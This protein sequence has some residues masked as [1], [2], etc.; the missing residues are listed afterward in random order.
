MN[1]VLKRQWFLSNTGTFSQYRYM[2]NSI[3]SGE[4]EVCAFEKSTTGHPDGANREDHWSPG[5]HPCHCEHVLAKHE[6]QKQAILTQNRCPALFTGKFAY[7]TMYKLA[8][9]S[10]ICGLG[11]E[12]G[13]GDT[14][15]GSTYLEDPLNS[16]L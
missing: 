6:K 11:G 14:Q 4:V 15:F 13:L 3:S 1:N 8:N 9:F 5:I 12:W 10:V 2:P 7:I 16:I